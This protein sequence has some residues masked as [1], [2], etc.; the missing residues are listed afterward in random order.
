MSDGNLLRFLTIYDDIYKTYLWGITLNMYVALMSASE[1]IYDVINMVAIC[2]YMNY[3]YFHQNQL[4]TSHYNLFY[5]ENISN[6]S[7]ITHD[8]R[9]KWI[10]QRILLYPV[11]RPFVH[12]LD[13]TFF[14]LKP[15]YPGS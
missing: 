3:S 12:T 11:V 1:S 9:I 4:K 10:G 15:R 8:R 2:L 6:E 14:L 7:D 13:N 5:K